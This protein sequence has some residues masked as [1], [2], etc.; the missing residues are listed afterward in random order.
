MTGE[1]SQHIQTPKKIYRHSKKTE[2]AST[3]S[4]NGQETSKNENTEQKN[5]N[6]NQRNATTPSSFAHTINITTTKRLKVKENSKQHDGLNKDESIFSD[7]DIVK[8]EHK[9]DSDATFNETK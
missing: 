7:E 9:D 8:N 5:S 3:L 6:P 1:T 4:S 2:A